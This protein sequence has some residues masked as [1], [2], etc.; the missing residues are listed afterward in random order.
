MKDI[1][2]GD[3]SIKGTNYGFRRSFNEPRTKITCFCSSARVASVTGCVPGKK[4]GRGKTLFIRFLLNL[5]G[6]YF[7]LRIQAF[8]ILTSS[9]RWKITV[10][11]PKIFLA[12]E[13]G[14]GW[15]VMPSAIRSFC[16]PA[17]YFVSY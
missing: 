14:M 15:K 12:R 8:G 13:E 11:H 5:L 2:V 4:R 3:S 6:V 9:A 7:S 17:V 10:A 1:L 16:K